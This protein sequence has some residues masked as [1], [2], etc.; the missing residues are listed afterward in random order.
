MINGSVKLSRSDH[1]GKWGSSSVPG[2]FA[3]YELGER[4]RWTNKYLVWSLWSFQ[5]TSLASDASPTEFTGSV[6]RVFTVRQSTEEWEFPLRAEYVATHRTLKGINNQALIDAERAAEREIAEMQ[7]ARVAGEEPEAAEPP[8]EEAPPRPTGPDD[9]V[10]H[11]GRWCLPRR[12]DGRLMPV[13]ESG[14]FVRK[15]AVQGE[16]ARPVSIPRP[17][18]D[19]YNHAEKLEALRELKERGWGCRFFR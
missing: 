19:M 16:L 5:S 6:N 17:L 14:T 3:G 1:H 13:D 18:W 11:R 12:G 8:P 4:G 9:Y 2:V 10:L 7:R 15:R